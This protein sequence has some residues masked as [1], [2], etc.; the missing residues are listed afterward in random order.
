MQ[1]QALSFEWVASWYGFQQRT[2]SYYQENPARK[3][4]VLRKRFQITFLG[5]KP[6]INL[7]WSVGSKGGDFLGGLDLNKTSNN[8]KNIR[9][10]KIP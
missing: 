8:E 9:S 6:L 3:E 7:N 2:Y 4:T 5:I 10:R 1:W